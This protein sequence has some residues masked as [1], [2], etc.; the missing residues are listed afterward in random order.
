MAGDA[1]LFVLATLD[2][3]GE[4]HGH[5]VIREAAVDSLAR[6]AHVSQGALYSA[7]RKCEADGLV[8]EVRT[9]QVGRFPAR[10]VYRLTDHGLIAL[11][12]GRD[13]AWTRTGVPADPFDL[14]LSVSDGADAAVLRTVIEGR[15]SDY[16]K[17][18]TQLRTDY[19]T[20]DDRLE[21]TARAVFR[22][23]LMRHETEIA[24][25]KE[26]LDTVDDFGTQRAPLEKQ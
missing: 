22:H 21:P 18:L 4:A 17:A 12:E 15:L 2:R 26:L 14:A 6:W 20:L 5:Q 13:R 11:E 10:T 23:V 19:E 24:W 3:L 8:S 25:H 7:L 1:R 16:S 9:E